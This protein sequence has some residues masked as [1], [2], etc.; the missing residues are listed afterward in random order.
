MT[1]IR[2]VGNPLARLHAADAPEL[3]Q[4]HQG[5]CIRTEINNVSPFADHRSVAGCLV[6]IVMSLEVALWCGD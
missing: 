2:L 4:L 5:G 6:E 1:E 3:L